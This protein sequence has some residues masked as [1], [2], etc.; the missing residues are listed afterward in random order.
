VKGRGESRRRRAAAEGGEGKQGSENEGTETERACGGAEGAAADRERVENGES[1]DPEA[2]RGQQEGEG[3][4]RGKGGQKE[5]M[6]GQIEGRGATGRA[7]GGTNRGSEIPERGREGTGREEDGQRRL[8]LGAGAREEEQRRRAAERIAECFP[9]LEA[10]LIRTILVR[11]HTVPPVPS[12]ASSA[13]PGAEVKAGQSLPWPQPQGALFPY[14]AHACGLHFCIWTGL[15]SF[16]VLC[17]GGPLHPPIS[18][19]KALA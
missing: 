6:G 5:G 4:Q 3:E 9:T 14:E 1:K 17:G 10:S 2:E 13:L 19:V 8:R 7:K 12:G 15:S 16:C 18:L 11:F